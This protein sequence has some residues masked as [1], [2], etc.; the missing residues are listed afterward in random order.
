MLFSWCRVD[1]DPGCT[2]LVECLK[3]PFFCST[4]KCK[5]F[6][7]LWKGFDVQQRVVGWYSLVI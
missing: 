1:T 6:F 4:K 2:I 3:I 7:G 5:G